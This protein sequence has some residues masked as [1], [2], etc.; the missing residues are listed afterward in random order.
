MDEDPRFPRSDIYFY[1]SCVRTYVIA[2]SVF[3]VDNNFSATRGLSF[4]SSVDYVRQL[5]TQGGRW[6]SHN[7]RVVL[8]PSCHVGWLQ[9]AS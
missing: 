8:T 9:T 2:R 4:C 3:F 5:R 6:R 7:S 1:T